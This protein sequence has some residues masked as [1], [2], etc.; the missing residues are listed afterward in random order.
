LKVLVTGAGGMVGRAVVGHCESQGDEVSAF[1]RHAL[2]ITDYAN[3]KSVFANSRPDAVI[4]CA[5]WTDVDGCESNRERAFAA[6]AQGP[7]NL[8]RASKE[9]RACLLTISTDYVFDGTKGDFYTQRDDPNPQSVYAL[10]K[11]EGER[12]AQLAHA[13]TIV[14]RSGF[15][16]GPG[17]RNFLSNVVDLARAGK[18]IKA[19]NDAYGTPTYALDLAKQLRRLALL[20]LPGVYHVVNEGRGASYEE[21]VRAILNEANLEADVVGVAMD[22]ITRPAPRPRDSRLKC[23]LSPRLGLPELPSWREAVRDF[24]SRSAKQ[25]VKVE[26]SAA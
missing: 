18:P 1:D 14:V 20:D 17:G 10:S 21:I 12:L 8:A 6:N 19:I 24:V 9:L 3:V 22:S 5:A 15:I 26:E 2:D 23:L 11:L 16:F 25:P 7:E 13:R 4:N